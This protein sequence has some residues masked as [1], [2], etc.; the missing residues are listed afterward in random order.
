MKIH[1]SIWFEKQDRSLFGARADII[2]LSQDYDLWNYC[3]HNPILLFTNL[4]RSGTGCVKGIRCAKEIKF[5]VLNS[6]KEIFSSVIPNTK[7]FG[8]RA[9]KQQTEIGNDI[10]LKN[11]WSSTCNINT[12][13]IDFQFN[14]KPFRASLYDF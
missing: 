3:L 14:F 13:I 9:S 5:H 6:I 8:S 7:Q 2:A 11:N 1:S 4:L 10:I 12:S